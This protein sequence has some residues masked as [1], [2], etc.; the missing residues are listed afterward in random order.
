MSY[1]GYFWQRELLTNDIWY[2]KKSLEE[3]NWLSFSSGSG[4]QF[5][6][7]YQCELMQISYPEIVVMQAAKDGLG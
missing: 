6:I 7:A 2:P 5:I 4:L 1:L 3:F